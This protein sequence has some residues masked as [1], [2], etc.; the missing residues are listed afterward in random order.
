MIY[1]CIVNIFNAIRPRRELITPIL[2]SLLRVQSNCTLFIIRCID[3]YIY[4]K[5][6][7]WHISHL[8][9]L[10]FTLNKK[11][12]IVYSM[13]QTT[14]VVSGRL[15]ET[16]R[17]LIWIFTKSLAKVDCFFL[18]IFFFAFILFFNFCRIETLPPPLNHR[19]KNKI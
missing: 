17:Y 4:C 19:H 6:I 8:N 7:I 14:V 15:R 13:N 1:E 16:L 9:V 12:V 11:Y 18:F 5:Y 3:N 2:L 10:C